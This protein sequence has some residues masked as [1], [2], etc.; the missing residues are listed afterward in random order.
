MSHNP[1]RAE[2]VK[3]LCQEKALLGHSFDEVTLFCIM[4][5]KESQ[6]ES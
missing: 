5:S 1:H 3:R 6:P 4:K 2:A